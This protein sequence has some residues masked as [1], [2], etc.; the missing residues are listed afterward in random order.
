MEAVWGDCSSAWWV[1][2]CAP[3]WSITEFQSVTLLDQHMLEAISG[4]SS[5]LEAGVSPTCR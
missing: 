3:R 5:M 4:N 1:H 2:S